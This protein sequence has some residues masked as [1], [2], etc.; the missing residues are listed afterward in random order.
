MAYKP[1]ILEVAAGGTG[2]ATLTGVLT[3]NGTSA[4]TASTV[5]QNGVLYGGASN[6]VSSLAV[7]ASGTV[8]TGT[9]GA[10][11]FSATPSVTSISFGGTAL[12]NYLESTFTPT[13]TASTSN[14]TVTYTTQTG[15]YTRIGNRVYT[16]IT[17]VLAT[18]SAG[19]GD[20]QISGLPVTSSSSN[21]AV[22]AIY[23]DNVTFATTYIN[24]V[25]AGS[26]TDIKIIGTT[27]AS[28][29]TTLASGA[30]GATT[31][32]RLTIIYEV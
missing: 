22:G 3:G 19:T 21:V 27:S 23:C 31:S 6:A 10:P 17:L 8:L 25:L 14:P 29:S 15:R 28:G 13:V 12:A 32:I 4:V 26:S 1:K 2:A 11:A 30:F 5:T 18:Y 9:G 20:V 16:T 7:A 24:P